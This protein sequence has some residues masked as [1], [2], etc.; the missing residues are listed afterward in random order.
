MASILVVTLLISSII[1]WCETPHERF[2]SIYSR[3]AD[4]G[5]KGIDVSQYVEALDEVLELLK[6]GDISR[7]EEIMDSISTNLSS[8]ESKVGEILLVNN[9]KRYGTALTLLIT[10]LLTYLLLPRVY[11]Y[12]WFRS[13]RKW[14]IVGERGKR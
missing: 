6:V 8:V 5:R 12:L 7:A 11:I 1:A 4:L 2:I 14:V 3:V 13:R 9:L 10:P